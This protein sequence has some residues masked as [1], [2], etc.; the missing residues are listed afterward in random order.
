M[1]LR[2]LAIL[3]ITALL[4]TACGEPAGDEE[5]DFDGTQRPAVPAE[6]TSADD[7]NDESDTDS[8]E[9]DST[10]ERSATSDEYD[11]I[12]LTVSEVTLLADSEVSANGALEVVVAFSNDSDQT[13]EL[14]FITESYTLFDDAGLENLPTE[15]DDS[16]LNPT[17]EPGETVSGTLRYVTTD[18]SSTFFLEVGSFDQITVDGN[19]DPETRP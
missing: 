14:P 4:V 2:T 11:G 6:A 18:A 10:G 17:I 8:D 19:V 7:L 5:I 16:L 12:T 1:K 3:V 9:T 13:A 15:V